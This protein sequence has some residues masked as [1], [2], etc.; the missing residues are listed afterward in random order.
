MY[1]SENLSRNARFPIQASFHHMAFQ[2]EH[3]RQCFIQET[4]RRAY[5]TPVPRARRHGRQVAF[6]LEW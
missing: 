3:G 1:T 4:P 6:Q 5:A 2:E